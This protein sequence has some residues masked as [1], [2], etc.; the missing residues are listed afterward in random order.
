M[1]SNIELDRTPESPASN[2]RTR[3]KKKKNE[4]DGDYAQRKP[5]HRSSD[6]HLTR[7]NLFK[8]Q[9]AMARIGDLMASARK[10]S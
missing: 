1:I 2:V 5:E 6:T 4:M 9:L 7:H 10:N 8:A 3:E